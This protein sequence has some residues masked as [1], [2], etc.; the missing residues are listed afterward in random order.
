MGR[1]RGRGNTEMD[2]RR[3]REGKGDKLERG[4]ELY[5]WTSA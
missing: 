3:G 1:E 2:K 5:M 4:M